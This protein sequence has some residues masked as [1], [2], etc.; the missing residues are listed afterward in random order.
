MLGVVLFGAVSYH[1]YEDQRPPNT[2]FH[3][4]SIRLD[5][6]PANKPCQDGKENCAQWDLTQLDSYVHKRMPDKIL[7]VSAFPAFVV[8]GLAVQGLGKLGISQVSSF[9]PLMPILIFA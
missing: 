4:S 3:W 5:R 9:L 2:D 8:G 6:N 7:M 1:S